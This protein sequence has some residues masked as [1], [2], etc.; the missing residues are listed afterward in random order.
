[1]VNY[2]LVRTPERDLR[3]QV[4]ARFAAAGALN[5]DGLEREFLDARWNIAAAPLAGH[6][7][8]LAISG[9]LEHA[10]MIGE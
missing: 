8:A 5:C 2:E 9:H 7:E 10:S 3:W 4:P 1:L 6:H